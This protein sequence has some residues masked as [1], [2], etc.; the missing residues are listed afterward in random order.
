MFVILLLTCRSYNTI[1]S[2]W[3]VGVIGSI[4]CD[5]QNTQ[6]KEQINM[7]S[8]SPLV[9]PLCVEL[10]TSSKWSKG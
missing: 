5:L 2:I 6:Y 8:C 4:S 1:T 3:K 10:H 9:N 7:L